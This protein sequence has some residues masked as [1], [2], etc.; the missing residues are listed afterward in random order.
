[1][2]AESIEKN[3]KVCFTVYGDVSVK[4]EAWAP[5]V[6]SAVVFGRCRPIADR[7][8]ALTLVRELAEKYYPEKQLIDGEIAASGKA[9]QMFEIEIEHLSGKEIQEK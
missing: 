6:K 9:V 2:K 1:H 8:A 4:D 5:Y 7:D 3:D